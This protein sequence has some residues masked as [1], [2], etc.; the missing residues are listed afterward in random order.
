MA[1]IL[2]VDDDAAFR[3]SLAETIVS[4]GH[5]VEEAASG[6]EAIDCLQ[7]RSVDL[8][9]MDFRMPGMTGL[10]VL[11]HLRADPHTAHL[12]VI[13]LTAFAES[14]NTIEAMKLGAFDHLTKPVGRDDVQTVLT[15]ALARPAADTLLARRSGADDSGLMGA[16]RSMREVQKLIGLASASDVPTLISGETGTGKELVARA[17]YGHGSRA[18]RPFVAVNCAAIPTELLE[19]ELFGHVKGAFTGALADH[20]GRFREADG[21]TLFLDEIGDMP[22]A[23]QAKLLRVLQDHEV[24]PLGGSKRQRVD[25]RLI[26]AT[27]KNLLAL[28]KESRFREDLFYRLKVFHIHLPPLRER[29]SDILLLAEHFLYQASTAA[30]KQLTAAAAQSLLEYEWPGNVREL[31]NL[32]RHLTVLVRGPVIDKADL[33]ISKKEPASD[34]SLGSLDGLLQMPLPAAMKHLE[35]HLI[36][37]ALQ[38]A[39]GNRADAARRLGIHRQLLYA[40]LKE[41]GL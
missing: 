12:P 7:S 9:M 11:Q 8:I 2:I 28:V 5:R 25:I 40:K 36:Q 39:H 18:H 6:R 19:S 3:D 14:H 26:A 13:I 23:M 31:E 22:L 17:L 20:A 4:F 27:N 34:L 32:M 15:R 24:Q 16:S 30:P 41:Y 37:Q 33:A 1:T 29:G 10:D 35:K 38:A 21:G